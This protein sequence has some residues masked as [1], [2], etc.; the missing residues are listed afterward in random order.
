MKIILIIILLIFN[1][2]NCDLPVHC[3]RN[4]IIGKWTAELTCAKNSIDYS[5]GIN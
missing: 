2:I 4:Q 1:R 3:L 5:C